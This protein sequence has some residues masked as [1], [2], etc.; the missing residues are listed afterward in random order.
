MMLFC[1]H[2]VE[3]HTL[4]CFTEE[5]DIGSDTGENRQTHGVRGGG[6]D[7]DMDGII[8]GSIPGFYN[9]VQCQTVR[10]R[11]YKVVP[12]DH[13]LLSSVGIQIAAPATEDDSKCMTLLV[14]TS[15]IKKVLIHFGRGMPVLFLYIMPPAA[16]RIRAALNMESKIGPYPRSQDETHKRTTLLPE[17][18]YENTKVALKNIFGTVANVLEELSN[19]EANDILVRASPKEVQNIMKKVTGMSPSKP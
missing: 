10:I 9:H 13:I 5:E 16:A 2:T 1:N 11:S 14:E 8:H 6:R 17:S 12:K 15:E 3:L 19:K 18:L 7:L 4:Y